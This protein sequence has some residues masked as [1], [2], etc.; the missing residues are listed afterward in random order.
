M[1]E[2]QPHQ[3]AAYHGAPE[4]IV[5]QPLVASDA[6]ETSEAVAFIPTSAS[7]V[8][9]ETGM[10]PVRGATISA[11]SLAVTGIVAAIIV[12]AGVACIATAAIGGVV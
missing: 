12:V 4:P 11:R 8:S 3:H 2:V 9:R 1:S 6:L 7:A 10:I 5:A